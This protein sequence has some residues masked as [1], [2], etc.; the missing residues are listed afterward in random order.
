M[1]KSE[2]GR[3]M[4]RLLTEQ[5]ALVAKSAALKIDETRA[6]VEPRFEALLTQMEEQGRDVGPVVEA[7]KAL[8]LAIKKASE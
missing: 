4:R 3:E 6:T 1:M 2:G 5:T 8:W 7:Y